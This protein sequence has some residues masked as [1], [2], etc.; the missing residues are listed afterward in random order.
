MKNS[1]KMKT[2]K[3]AKREGPRKHWKQTGSLQYH[4][5]RAKSKN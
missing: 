5:S 4:E 2:V 1:D 3:N